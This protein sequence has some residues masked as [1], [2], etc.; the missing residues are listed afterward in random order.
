MDRIKKAYHLFFYY[1]IAF[2]F[3]KKDW[4]KRSV[5]ELEGRLY[6][7]TIAIIIIIGL[8]F[9]SLLFISEIFLGYTLFNRESGIGYVYMLI[10][11]VVI[12]ALFYFSLICKDKW[13]TYVKEFESYT[14]TKI[15]KLSFL[16]L[17]FFVFYI[18]TIIISSIVW[19]GRYDAGLIL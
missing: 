19:K 1:I 5:E 4:Y 12:Y 11:V 14:K 8:S 2:S 7:G 9:L 17:L 6:S 16:M 3:S 15:R 18:L 13:K 10:Y